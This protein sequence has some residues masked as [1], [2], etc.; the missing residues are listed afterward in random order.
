MFLLFFYHQRI[1]TN[2]CKIATGGLAVYQKDKHA[3]DVTVLRR[4]THN[5]VLYIV[6][7]KTA[8]T[9]SATLSDACEN[10]NKSKFKIEIFQHN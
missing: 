3:R 2:I 6:S 8:S 1:S 10:K 9:I 7:A 5:R 4:K